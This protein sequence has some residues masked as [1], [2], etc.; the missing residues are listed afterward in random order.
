[1]TVQLDVEKRLQG[2][3]QDLDRDFP[4]AD[5]LERLILARVEATPRVSQQRSWPG[6]LIAVLAVL[7]LALGVAMTTVYLRTHESALP[8]PRPTPTPPPVSSEG[9]L[10]SARFFSAQAG[11]VQGT[12]DLLITDDGGQHWQL[13][14]RLGT[15][16]SF[17][18]VRF[19]D[20]THV[21]AV[22]SVTTSSCAGAFG[23]DPYR[24]ATELYT[25]NDG[26]A[27][28]QV[29]QLKAADQSGR[30]WDY[31]FF[32]DTHEGWRLK[33]TYR[34]NP[35]QELIP[36][37]VV[38]Y[39]T[40][41]SG[42]HWTALAGRDP[43]QPQLAAHGLQLN[44]VPQGGV[45]IDSSHGF[46]G[47]INQQEVANLY[48]TE[49]G[50]RNWRLTQLP[51]PP[52][53]WAALWNPKPGGSAG[54]CCPGISTSVLTDGI[55]MFGREG[56]LTP[57]GNLVYSTVD[58]GLTWANP[59][60]L[61]QGLSIVF[62]DPNHWLGMSS[63]CCAATVDALFQTS[64]A[65]KS[66]QR[67]ASAPPPGTSFGQLIY[68]SPG[69]IWARASIATLSCVP[70]G[71]TGCATRVPPGPSPS[72]PAVCDRPGQKASPLG[73]DLLIRSSDGG[74]HWTIVLGLPSRQPPN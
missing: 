58:G 17:Q 55:A 22:V 11:W 2:D 45:F 39:H 12:R 10:V 56:V 30:T 18:S 65:G 16:R 14:L 73:C 59:R 20:R 28:W 24:C 52:G 49:D 47:V 42:A 51:P 19:F 46:L 21:A 61:P 41:D 29:G 6:Q 57:W 7:A 27:H 31:A 66:W 9:P 74:A 32:V 69:V 4:G 48:F 37:T 34:V 54:P 36:E 53:G 72:V 64:D 15:D 71:P 70:D 5:K 43:S 40:V 3:A 35:G 50:G 8:K 68:A 25:T 60:S 13:R 1:M 44:P 23:P 67:L 63:T 33:R 26:G 38:L 62:L